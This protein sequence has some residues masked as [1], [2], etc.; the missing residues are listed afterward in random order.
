MRLS[1]IALLLALLC[2]AS[3]SACDLEHGIQV[4]GA[5]YP[6][7]AE[8]CGPV[9]IQIGALTAGPNAIAEASEETCTVRIKP[10][11]L[12]DNSDSFICDLLGHEWGHLAG[13]RF[14]ENTADPFHSLD[15]ANPMYFQLVHRPVCGESDAA[16]AVRMLREQDAA[17]S[18]E[19]RAEFLAGRREEIRDLLRDYK[20][21]LRYA[22]AQRRR[23][24]GPRRARLDR[25]IKKIRRR[26]ARLRAEYAETPVA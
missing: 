16:A 18:R 2:A 3:A 21:D 7:V 1:G 11:V 22:K 9:S 15:P 12:T 14:P 13:L 26:V 25:E 20:R 24:R 6:S 10:G 19:Q 17:R 8:R 5:T 23:A 4:A